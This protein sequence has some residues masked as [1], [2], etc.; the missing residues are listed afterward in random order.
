[1]NVLGIAS[2]QFWM[3][4]NGDSSFSLHLGVIKKHHC[5]MKIVKPSFLQI[6]EPLNTNM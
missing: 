5:E 3:H 6:T 4:F 1:M 2:S